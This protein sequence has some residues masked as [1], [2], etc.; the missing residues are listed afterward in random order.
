MA[1]AGDHSSMFNVENWMFKVQ[2]FRNLKESLFLS[3]GHLNFEFVSN[4]VLCI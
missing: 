4:F 3:F 2:V 1:A